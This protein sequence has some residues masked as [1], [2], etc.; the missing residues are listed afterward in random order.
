MQLSVFS[1]PIISALCYFPALCKWHW[2]AD[3][4]S[5]STEEMSQSFVCQALTAHLSLRPQIHITLPL[6]TITATT[7][8]VH[9]S[10]EKPTGSCIQCLPFHSNL[11]KCN[12]TI[13]TNYFNEYPIYK[14]NDN[15]KF[16]KCVKL[17][18]VCCLLQS[19]WFSLNF[20]PL[21]AARGNRCQLSGLKYRERK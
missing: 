16:R 21:D 4:N 11:L 1:F 10:A 15:D 13:K 17:F 8:T 7:A 5:H 12:F 18:L 3:V 14:K 20:F 2:L 6:Q 19:L 9:S